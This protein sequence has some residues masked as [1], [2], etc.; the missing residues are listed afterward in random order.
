MNSPV[1]WI[2]GGEAGHSGT[3]LHLSG[4]RFPT[5]R[6]LSQGVVFQRLD[7]DWNWFSGSLASGMLYV[8]STA[9]V[10][11]TTVGECLLPMN[12]AYVIKYT[13][14]KIHLHRIER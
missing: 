10:S 1:L 12:R 9:A 7:S 14:H 6:L 8:M 4:A 3:G 11:G 13:Y 5:Q 2:Q